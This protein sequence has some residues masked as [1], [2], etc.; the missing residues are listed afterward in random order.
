MYQ[1]N[2]IVTSQI[3]KTYPVS[4]GTGPVLSTPRGTYFALLRTPG[5]LDS[6][7]GKEGSLEAV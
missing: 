7:R 3:T 6:G 4:V 1:N 2:Y 5:A